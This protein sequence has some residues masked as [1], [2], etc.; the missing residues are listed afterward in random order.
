MLKYH[1][2]G[3]KVLRKDMQSGA[4]RTLSHTQRQHEELSLMVDPSGVQVS[5]GGVGTA[6]VLRADLL[7]TNGVHVLLALL[8]KWR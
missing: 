3:N 7:A 4:V 8:Y 2:L 6:R 1:V 5:N